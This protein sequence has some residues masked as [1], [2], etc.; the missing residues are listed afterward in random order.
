MRSDLA[1]PLI[2][3]LAEHTG[4]CVERKADLDRG[5]QSAA[6]EF[7]FN[8]QEAF[9]TWLLSGM[10]ER[11]QLERLSSHLT[12]GETYFFREKGIFD[13]LED[14]ILPELL[15]SRSSIRIWSAGC[16]TGEEPYSIAMLLDRIAPG[17]GGIDILATDINPRFLEKAERGV[18]GEWSFRDEPSWIRKSC[19]RKSGKDH[20]ILPRVRE[21]VRFSSLN[22]A[23]DPYPENIDIVFCRNVLMYFS[24]GKAEQAVS[25]LYEAAAE[26][27]WL[28]VSPVEAPDR[29]FSRFESVRFPGATLHRKPPGQ[30]AIREEMSPGKKM[31][32]AEEQDAVFDAGFMAR[33]CADRGNLEE[34]EDWCKRAIEF[35]KLDPGKHYLHAVI[36]HEMGR[37]GEEEDALRRV[38]YLDPDFILAHFALGN[39][40]LSQWRGKEAAHHF[41]N[42]LALLEKLPEGKILPES[43]GL[44]AGRL[45]GIIGA[46]SGRAFHEG[47]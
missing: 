8:D 38:I 30:C 13:V 27:G 4:L 28:I 3:F 31:E 29:L 10:P 9:A 33:L 20:E 19:F 39:L 47:R 26:N 15:G 34:A 5:L 32:V 37:F 18:Y 41:R 24:R 17:R 45:A 25:G 12:V 14:Q 42:T 22:L 11:T 40:C 46:L 44:A 35:G 2:E 1:E 23:R 7:G 43:E 21:M 6:K 16:C 36:L